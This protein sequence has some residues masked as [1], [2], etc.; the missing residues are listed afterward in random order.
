MLTIGVDA[1]KQVHVAVA[2]DAAGR[3]QARWRGANTPAGWQE[4]TQWGRALAAER[5]WGSE[6]A[7]QYGRGLAQALVAAGERVVDVNPRLTAGERR[8]GRERGKTDPLDARSVARVVNRDTPG[9]PVVPPEDG[10]SL[11]ALWAQER[12]QLQRE[13][14]RLRNEAHHVLSLLDPAY[15]TTLA[16][17]TTP[18]AVATLVGYTVTDPQDV[19]AQ[20]RAAM[21]RR[22][23][24]RLQ[25]VTEQ[26]ALLTQQL[27]AAGRHS[28]QPLDD[29][30][31]VGPLTASELAGHLGPGKR[32]ATDAKVANHAGAAPVEASSG[33]VVRHRLNRGGNRQFNAILERIALTQGRGDPAARAYLARRRREGKTDREA[34]RALKRFL[35]RA[36]WRA[37]QDCPIPTLE[38]LAPL[39]LPVDHAYG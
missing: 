27:Q 26:L 22:L 18:T 28:L 29:R 6:G 38:D 20:A 33:A 1:H 9:L 4:L 11:L 35:C 3:E 2:V 34:R 13:A 17:L 36:I 12:T 23:G 21:V 8:A 16:D 19:L 15:Q 39:I 31:G 37:W 7:W 25:L 32:F 30:Y 24:H 10:S 5:Q 14:T